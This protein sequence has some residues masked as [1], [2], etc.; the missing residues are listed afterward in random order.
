MIT[1]EE[2]EWGDT[3]SITEGWGDGSN[4]SNS[5]GWGDN[6]IQDEENEILKGDTYILLTNSREKPFLC[7]VTLIDIENQILELTDNDEKVIIVNIDSNNNI[8]SETENYT[9]LEYI[10][11]AEYDWLVAPD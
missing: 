6:I 4:Y 9:I 1:P 10:K 7:S 2:N 3:S 11:V 8:I 5:G